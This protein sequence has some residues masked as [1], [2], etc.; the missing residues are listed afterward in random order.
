M[1][2]NLTIFGENPL[3]IRDNNNK[4][5]LYGEILEI[6]SNI[7]ENYYIPKKEFIKIESKLRSILKDT[8]LVGKTFISSNDKIYKST[9]LE[10]SIPIFSEITTIVKDIVVVKE[11]G[12]ICLYGNYSITDTPSG[13]VIKE[14]IRNGSK[15][16]SCLTINVNPL[17]NILKDVRFSNFDTIIYTKND[18]KIKSK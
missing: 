3:L 17:N 5:E 10:L 7:I 9:Y 12:K 15:F 8:R 14:L 6:D 18:L 2:K 16:Y 11:S 1:R 4:F 13:K